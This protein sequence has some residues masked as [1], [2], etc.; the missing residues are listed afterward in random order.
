MKLRQMPA[1]KVTAILIKFFCNYLAGSISFF[2]K[3]AKI[4]QSLWC[5]LCALE[6]LWPKTNSLPN[7]TKNSRAFI[8][9][10]N[11]LVLLFSIDFKT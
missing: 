11:S 4:A 6:S 3:D 5:N 10:K 7:K 8:L 9:K 1:G 2:H